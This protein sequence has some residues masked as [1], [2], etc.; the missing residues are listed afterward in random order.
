MKWGE[1]IQ[2][3]GECPVWLK[4]DEMFAYTNAFGE[5]AER[6]VTDSADCRTWFW[7]HIGKIKMPEGHRIYGQSH[8]SEPADWA[9]E[10]ALVSANEAIVLVDG[11]PWTAANIRVTSDFPFTRT[12]LEFARYIEQHELPPIDP[13][14]LAVR[15]ILIAWH[16]GEWPLLEDG[17]YDKRPDFQAALAV[18]RRYRHE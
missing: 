3:G 1:A 14:V 16:N 9:I 18:Y 8:D 6:T 15:E 10:K 5:W 17:A 7:G 13:D 11:T 12:V 4:S 2:T